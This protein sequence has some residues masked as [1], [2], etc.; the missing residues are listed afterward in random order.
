MSKKWY[1]Y[2]L[3]V[4]ALMLMNACQEK[5]SDQHAVLQVM[6]TDAPADYEE[7]LIDIRDV[8]IHVSDVEG[9]GEWISLQVNQGIYNL[10][11]FRNGMDT[12]LATLELPAGSI[13]Q[14]RLVLG[15]HNQVKT[16]GAFHDLKTPSAQQSGLKFSI[17]AHLT[18]GIVYKLWVD[19]DAARS[20]VE[21][22]ND[23]FILKPVI[24]TYT[25]A[26]SG[27]IAGHIDPP[28]AVPYVMAVANDDT[29]GAYAGEDGN[30]MLRGVP[31]G[32]WSVIIV[33]ADPYL[34]DTTDNVMVEN[35]LVTEMDTVYLTQ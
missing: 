19:F 12:L 35:G 14:M 21:T 32:S 15:E 23:G 13:S 22:G 8:Q 3:F 33:P 10:L 20:I 27:A 17:H 34:P 18:A 5:E 25:E 28:A 16:G 24:R 4:G 9:E 29:I 30:F 2:G 6:L 1:S 26:I 31:A 7:V 11:D